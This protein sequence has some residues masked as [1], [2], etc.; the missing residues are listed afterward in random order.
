MEGADIFRL[1]A[2]LCFV[3]AL[4]GGLTIILRKLGLSGVVPVTPAKRRLKI[5]ETLSLDARRRLVLIQRDDT[6]HLV[7]LGGTGETIVETNIKAPV[8]NEENSS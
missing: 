5:V 8:Y 4:M 2:A 6:Q 3:L 7:I 1:L